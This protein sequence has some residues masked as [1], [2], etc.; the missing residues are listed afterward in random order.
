MRPQTS[1]DNTVNDLRYEIKFENFVKDKKTF[2]LSETF[3]FFL[4]QK[5]ILF[6]E[7]YFFRIPRNLITSAFFWQRQ[8]LKNADLHRQ[9][10]QMLQC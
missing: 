5:N 1:V 6:S 4:E 3:L 7:T 2:L 8:I 9:K 10:S